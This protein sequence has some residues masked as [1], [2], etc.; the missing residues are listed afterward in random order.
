MLH[1]NEAVIPQGRG[2]ILADEIARAMDA[3]RGPS[4]DT[5]AVLEELRYLRASNEDLPV[6]IGR[7]LRDA[8]LLAR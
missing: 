2:H 1:G 7:S 5:A 8:M 6:A 3:R 4:M